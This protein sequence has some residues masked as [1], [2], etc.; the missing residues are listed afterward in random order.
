MTQ[1]SSSPSVHLNIS[2]PLDHGHPTNPMCQIYEFHFCSEEGGDNDEG[3]A[4][5]APHLCNMR[6][7]V[8]LP[9][10]L[11]LRPIDCIQIH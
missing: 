4:P 7:R 2:S 10:I 8:A 3:A 5:P 11:S 6:G 1:V 9:L